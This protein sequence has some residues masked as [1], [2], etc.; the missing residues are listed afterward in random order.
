M[1]HTTTIGG[2]LQEPDK[3]AVQANERDFELPADQKEP[4]LVFDEAGALQ[5]QAASDPKFQLYADGR[6]KAAN[7][8]KFIEF[9]LEPKQ[10]QQ[11]LKFIIHDQ[12]ICQYKTDV[13]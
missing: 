10:V 9:K 1:S 8:Q 3:K 4:I 11:L 7:G 13:S 2:L 12:K 6:V 5:K